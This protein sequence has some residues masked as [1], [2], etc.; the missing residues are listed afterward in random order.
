MDDFSEGK[1]TVRQAEAFDGAGAVL[2]QRNFQAN[3]FSNS[4]VFACRLEYP[5][6]SVLKKKK[7]KV[8]LCFFKERHSSKRCQGVLFLPSATR[9]NVEISTKS[10]WKCHLYWDWGKL[11][12]L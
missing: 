8:P 11:Q 10:G 7:E 12:I 3:V 2:A 5:H 1:G 9:C 4:S 6:Y